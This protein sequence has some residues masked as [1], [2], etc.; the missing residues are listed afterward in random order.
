MIKIAKD[1]NDALKESDEAKEYLKL[2]EVLKDDPFV[3][4]LLE[5]VKESQNMMKKYLDS[6][7]L[8]NYKIEKAKLELYKEQFVNYPLVSNYLKAK[9]DLSNLIEQIVMIIGE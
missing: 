1:I 9:S 6:N 4:K 5:N 2:K 3:N 7:D 8:A